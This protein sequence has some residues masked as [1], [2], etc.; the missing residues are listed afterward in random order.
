MKNI[1]TD[2]Q[3]SLFFKSEITD[4][5]GRFFHQL[6]VVQG[7]RLTTDKSAI[8]W[9]FPIDFNA[10]PHKRSPVV[11]RADIYIFTSNAQLRAIHRKSLDRYLSYYGLIR[12]GGSLAP[13]SSLTSSTHTW[14]RQNDINH[15]V[16]TRMIRSLRVLAQEDLAKN[17]AQEFIRI[18][19]QY[20]EVN[21]LTLKDWEDAS[22]TPPLV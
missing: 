10:H 13:K 5:Q 15:K 4:P 9:L 8:E 16:I 17:L 11:S 1:E 14:L 3:I 6:S 7:F 19:Q 20:G 18:A 22:V 2:S 21:S 12:L